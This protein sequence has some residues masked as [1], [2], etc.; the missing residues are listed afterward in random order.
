[1]DVQMPGMDGYE[2]TACIRAG[3]R[4]MRESRLP[5]IALTE[6]AL[7]VERERSISAGMEELKVLHCK[8]EVLP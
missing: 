2:T 4:K 8:F 6:H 7:R 1:M 3:E 5:V